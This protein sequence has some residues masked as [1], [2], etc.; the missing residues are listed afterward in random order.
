ETPNGNTHVRV[1]AYIVP[2]STLVASIPFTTG[3]GMF[4]PVDDFTCM[5]YFFVTQDDQNPQKYGGENLFAPAPYTTPMLWDNGV[6]NRTHTEENHYLI[7]RAAQKSSMFS[8]VSD[9]VSQDLMV[10]ESMGAIYDRSQEHL[11]TT[12]I[13]IIRMR[14]ILIDAVNALAAGGDVPAFEGEFTTIRAA[15]KIL[16]VD[17]DWRLLGTDIDPAVQEAGQVT[18]TLTALAT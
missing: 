17:E 1:T 5:R 18:S 12:D 15:E 4:V 11:G 3:H 9:F 8:G 2:Y 14:T 13:S 16:E 7:D 6:V 10:T